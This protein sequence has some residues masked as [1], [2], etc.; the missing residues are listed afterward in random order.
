MMTKIRGSSNAKAK[1]ELG[2]TLKYPSWRRLLPGRSLRQPEHGIVRSGA[3]MRCVVASSADE[4]GPVVS[5]LLLCAELL[6]P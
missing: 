4:V 2:W 3:A 1:R 6:K 5:V